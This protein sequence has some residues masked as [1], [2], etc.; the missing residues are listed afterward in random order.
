MQQKVA[1]GRSLAVDFPI[2]L[3]DEPFGSLDVE[4]RT[5]MQKTLIDVSEKSDKLIILVTHDLNEAIL[6]SDVIYV[7]PKRPIS[8]ISNIIKVHLS[9][10][11]NTEIMNTNE[12]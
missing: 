6:L 12:F 9:K 1:I 2:L 5:E 8:L 4:T 7:L 10:Q 11:R 3:M